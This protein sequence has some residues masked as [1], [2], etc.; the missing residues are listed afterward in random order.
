MPDASGGPS[1]AFASAKIL[2][3][4]G[5][6]ARG[7][8]FAESQLDGELDP[9]TLEKVNLVVSELVTN[10]Y[11]H[12]E[13]AIELRLDVHREKIRIEVVDQGS[14]AVPEIRENAGEGGGWG[15][16]VIDTLAT[17]WGVFE[18]TTHV[19]AELPTGPA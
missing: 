5:C 15:L 11:Q 7:R 8:R 14:G 17:A 16:M 4:P 18:G 2:R 12:G 10:A 6:A 1:E 3:G 9:D 13:G 19:W